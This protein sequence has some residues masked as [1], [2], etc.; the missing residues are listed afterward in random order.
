MDEGRGEEEGEA[1]TRI[2][3]GTSMLA[4]LGAGGGAG[5]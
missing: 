4:W 1:S 2:I 5:A 3:V